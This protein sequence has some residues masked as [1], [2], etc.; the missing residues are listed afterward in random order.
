MSSSAP[1]TASSRS[2]AG[3]RGPLHALGLAGVADVVAIEAVAAVRAC[4]PYA[5]PHPTQR[6]SPL[7]R[8]C[9]AVD[10]TAVASDPRSSSSAWARAKVVALTDRGVL[11]VVE[12]VLMADL[13][14]VD[15]VAQDA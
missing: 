7:S 9:D 5:P 3:T 6:R 10:G 2:S 4:A 8:Y 14:D 1:T 11:A 13:A 12:R 15:R